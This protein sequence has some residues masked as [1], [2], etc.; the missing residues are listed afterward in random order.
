[1]LKR[2]LRGQRWECD[3]PTYWRPKK[4]DPLRRMTAD[5]VAD[6]RAAFAGRDRLDELDKI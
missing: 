1:M 5:D 4:A 2:Q 6:V 3:D